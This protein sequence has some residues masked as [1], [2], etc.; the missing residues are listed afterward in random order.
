MAGVTIN[1][2]DKENQNNEDTVKSISLSLPSTL[3]LLKWI[4][5]KQRESPIF[6]YIHRLSGKRE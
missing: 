3:V 6:N 5:F 4:I 1:H 2:R